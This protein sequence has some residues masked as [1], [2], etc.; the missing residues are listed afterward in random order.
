[1]VLLGDQPG[2]TPA[3]VAAVVAAFR[4][5]LGPVVQASY[6]GRAAHPTLLARSVWADVVA[7]GV[8]ANAVASVTTSRTQ[9]DHD[10]V[11]AFRVHGHEEYY[12]EVVEPFTG[13]QHPLVRVHPVTGRR[14]LYLAGSFMRHIVGLHDDE[15]AA[16][17][18][19]AAGEVLVQALKIAIRMIVHDRQAVD[20]DALRDGFVVRH[21]HRIAGIIRTVAG[22][23]DHPPGGGDVLLAYLQ[24]QRP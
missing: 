23:I 19:D 24:Q 10:A 6:G 9:P 13:A 8:P 17:A 3:A 12:R 2:T 15:S 4:A 16:P 21:S 20:H 5:G 1:M 18:G 22:H 11:W 7:S 14:A